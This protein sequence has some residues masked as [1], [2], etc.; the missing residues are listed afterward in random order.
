VFVCAVVFVYARMCAVICYCVCTVF[1]STVSSFAHV[2][3]YF[4]YM[5]VCVCVCVRARVCV[6]SVFVFNSNAATHETTQVEIHTVRRHVPL[7]PALLNP[8]TTP[9]SLHHRCPVLRIAPSFC[10]SGYSK[11]E[12]RSLA[13]SFPHH[14]FF[15]LRSYPC[16]S[17]TVYAP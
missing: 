11:R 13:R 5:C 10:R 3:V 15:Q 6:L 14:L 4:V 1:V 12:R 17:P 8:Q 16:T 7:R 2:L 9:I